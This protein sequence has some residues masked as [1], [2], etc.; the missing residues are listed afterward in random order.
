MTA[1]D[2]LDPAALAGRVAM[3]DERIAGLAA[4]RRSVLGA[5][6]IGAPL[7]QGVQ[8]FGPL[9]EKHGLGAAICRLEVAKAQLGVARAD[10]GLAALPAVDAVAGGL[11]AAEEEARAALAAYAAAEERAQ[12]LRAE[13]RALAGR[14][15][16]LRADRREA[17]LAAADWRR[18]LEGAEEALGAALARAGRPE[19]PAAWVAALMGEDVA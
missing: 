16:A 13:R 2:L 3:I 11:A 19:T 5:V 8:D 10:A 14:E 18:S 7:L 15:Q 1:L 17:E 9:L 4:R 6:P 12:A